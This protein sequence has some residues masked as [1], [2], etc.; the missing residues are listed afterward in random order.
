M[1]DLSAFMTSSQ[2]WMTDDALV[3]IRIVYGTRDLDAIFVKPD[4]TE[5]R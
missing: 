1:A 2:W 5:E 4:D 3:V